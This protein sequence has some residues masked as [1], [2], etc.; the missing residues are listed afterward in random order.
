MTIFRH[1]NP[2]FFLFLS[3]LRFCFWFVVMMNLFISKGRIFFL[4]I[5]DTCSCGYGCV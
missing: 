3:V 5:V 2:V 1:C 4:E